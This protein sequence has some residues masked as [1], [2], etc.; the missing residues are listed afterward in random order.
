[1]PRGPL[2]LSLDRDN[3][4]VTL[5]MCDLGCGLAFL[6]ALAPPEP[7]SHSTEPVSHVGL[8]HTRTNQ[9]TFLPSQRPPL[10]G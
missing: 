7:C 2:F 10:L 9:V 1:M 5:S 6:W 3:P 8:S 4:A